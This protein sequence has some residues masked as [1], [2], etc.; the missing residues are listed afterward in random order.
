MI[1]V[2]YLARHAGRRPG[3]RDIALLDVCQDYA[4][5]LLDN[6][7]IFGFGVV[8]KGGTSLR[9]FRAGNA[10]R[11]SADLDLATTDAETAG[12][13][14]DTL[15][16]AEHFDVRM[17]VTNRDE[18][19]GRIEFQTPLGQ[20]VVPAK[21]ELSPRP[22]WLPTP[23]TT[24]IALP[25]HAGYEFTPPPLPVPA[26]EESIAEKLAAWLRRLWNRSTTTK[27]APPGAHKPIPTSLRNLSWP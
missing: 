24:P 5:D 20:P 16:G 15:D 8:L 11:F 13:V 14:L 10:G 2:G 23:R 3:D 17:R 18:L 7:G 12:L 6:Q 27:G 26:V 9:K 22:L 25:V 1:T 4:L 19:R 21:I